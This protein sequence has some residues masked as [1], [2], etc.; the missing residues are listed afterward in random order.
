MSRFYTE[1]GPLIRS[2]LKITIGLGGN[3]PT[4][5][6]LILMRYIHGTSHSDKGLEPILGL[7][8]LVLKLKSSGDTLFYKVLTTTTAS[9]AKP[10]SALLY[11]LGPIRHYLQ[12]FFQQS[13]IEG[14]IGT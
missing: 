12:P 11:Y 9:I 3:P 7:L 8:A 6:W 4:F 14:P 13:L 2:T 10:P 5:L 1:L